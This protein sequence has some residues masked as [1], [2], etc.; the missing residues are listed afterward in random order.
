MKLRSL[1]VFPVAKPL[2]AAALVTSCLVAAPMA[3]S[4]NDIGASERVNFSGKLRM[5]SQRT[6]AAAC[7]YTAG[8]AAEDSR[9]VLIGA[10]AEFTKITNALEFGDDDLNII[11][12]ETRR[13]TIHAIHELKTKWDEMSASI[14]RIA[15]GD[16]ASAHAARVAELNMGVLDKA[17]LL[18]GVI[19]AQYSN[20][21]EMV[22]A[23]SLLVDYSGRQR[24]LLQ[25]MSKESCQAW[26]GSAEA[27]EALNGTMQMFEATLIALRGGHET[28]GIKAAPTSD[29]DS[30]LSGLWNDWIELKPILSKAVAGES[31]DAAQ[32]AD[33]FAKLNTMLA[34]MNAVV[35][36]YTIFAKTGV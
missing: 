3:A 9:A 14:D 19:S 31:V 28:A 17:K 24:M 25:K 6:A 4:A 35:G 13:K 22:Q 30:G 33:V 16:D 5:L 1:T 11:G 26:S 18:V 32:R 27:T 23:D 34:D 12:A 8:I 7:N 15:E 2:M 10:Q 36:L 29:I 21:F 20:P